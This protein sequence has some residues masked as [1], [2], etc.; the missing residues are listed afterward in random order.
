MYRL[1][2]VWQI[3]D[4]STRADVTITNYPTREAKL[5]SDV[6]TKWIHWPTS[7]YQITRFLSVS[8]ARGMW[9]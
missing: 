8:S 3:T 4:T 5:M 9:M 1:V 2:V 6:L 7:A